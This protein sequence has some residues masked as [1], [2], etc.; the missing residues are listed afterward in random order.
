MNHDIKVGDV[1]VIVSPASS[2]LVGSECE[3]I[4]PEKVYERKIASTGSLDVIAW[5]NGF[6]VRVAC[7]GKRYVLERQCLRKKRPPADDDLLELGEDT[8]NKRTSW[9][10]VPG[11]VPPTRVKEPA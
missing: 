10:D 2:Q 8:P 4:G 3:V 1:C 6:L 7:D 5:C 9:S 11:Y